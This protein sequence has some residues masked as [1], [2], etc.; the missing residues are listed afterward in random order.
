MT[1][2][3]LCLVA[4]SFCFGVM[5]RYVIGWVIHRK[6]VPVWASTFARRNSDAD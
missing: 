6:D 3:I 1:V 2:L 5:A 4:S